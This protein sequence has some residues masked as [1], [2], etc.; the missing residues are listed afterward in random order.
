MSSTSNLALDFDIDHYINP[1]IPRSFLHLLPTPISCLLGYRSK[2]RPPIGSV[3]IWFGSFIGAF[4]GI[5]V[6]EA[7]FH[8][9]AFRS[10]G[11]PLIIASFVS[12]P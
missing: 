5:L 4:C 10:H 12:S 8:A 11:T 2:P 7:V 6:V 1:F 9:E 3:M